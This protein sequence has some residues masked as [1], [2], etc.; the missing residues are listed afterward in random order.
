[1]RLRDSWEYHIFNAITRAGAKVSLKITSELFPFI[2][3]NFNSHIIAGSDVCI[4]VYNIL[5][6]LK[7]LGYDKASAGLLSYYRV[8][9]RERVYIV[10][11]NIFQRKIYFLLSDRGSLKISTSQSAGVGLVLLYFIH[12]E[13]FKE[14]LHTGELRKAVSP[15]RLRDESGLRR[16]GS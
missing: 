5:M 6:R 2:C 9:T 12:P 14:T 16:V 15:F 4:P 3:I 11:Y 1:M 13:F 10:L 8:I 7:A